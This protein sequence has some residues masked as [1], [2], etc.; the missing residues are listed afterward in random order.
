MCKKGKSVFD[1]CDFILGEGGSMVI[2]LP[3]LLPKDAPNYTVSATPA[4]IR[5]KAGHDE[6]AKFPYQSSDVFERLSHVSQVGIIEFPP[7]DFFP[8]CITAVAYVETRMA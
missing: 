4:H 6:I 7:E 3:G 2:V 8:G 1:R 5:I